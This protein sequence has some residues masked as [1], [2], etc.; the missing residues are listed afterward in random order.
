MRIL[1]L[2]PAARTG[3]AS[4]DHAGKH[5]PIYGTHQLPKVE[6]SRQLLAFE[7]FLIDKIKGGAI[8]EVYFEQ[9]NMQDRASFD[10]LAAVIGKAAIIGV[11]CARLGIRCYP[12]MMQVWR[13][14]FGVPTQTPQSVK[15]QFRAS[16]LSESAVKT[17]SSKWLKQQTID[18]CEKLGYSP[19]DD[20]AADGLAI[21]IIIKRRKLD[22][23]AAPSIFSTDMT[24]GLT[25]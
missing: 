11:T 8:E 3:W 5:P 12:V 6:T 17:A 21:W 22:R 14:E 9:P 23:E 16:G 25:I 10:A 13:S 18:K 19:K 20:N 15:K 2:D 1:A 24:E 7:E 4:G